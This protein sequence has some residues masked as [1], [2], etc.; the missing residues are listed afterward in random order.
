MSRSVS[1]RLKWQTVSLADTDSGLLPFFIEWNQES[2]HPSVDAP[3]G[4]A[5]LSF[6]AETRE[7][8]LLTATVRA[9]GI[10]LPVKKGERRRLHAVISGPKG[11]LDVY[12]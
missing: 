4:C 5:L 6:T 8:D 7:P 11:N 2:V 10:D 9:L 3:K 1:R 12:S